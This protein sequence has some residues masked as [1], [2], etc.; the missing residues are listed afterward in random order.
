M[1]C[2]V[3]IWRVVIRVMVFLLIGAVIN[4]LVAAGCAARCTFADPMNRILLLTPNQQVPRDGWCSSLEAWTNI[5]TW[6]DTPART[7]Q[8][9]S[10]ARSDIDRMFQSAWWLRVQISD[11]HSQT[12]LLEQASG[13]ASR[14]V[15]LTYTSTYQG[16]SEHRKSAVLET[17]WPL[18]SFS[19]LGHG[20]WIIDFQ[21]MQPALHIG[22]SGL[23]RAAT[24]VP[25]RPL[26][27]GTLV[28]TA[29]YA[30]L[31]WMVI[32]VPQAIRHARRRKHGLCIACKYPVNDLAKCPECGTPVMSVTS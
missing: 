22:D 8:G 16:T 4:W 30:A 17:G 28:N 3:K 7:P 24:I 18:L 19:C 2:E 9:E 25:L 6:I 26:F 13:M 21:T 15:Q 12:L 31:T 1:G 14:H 5:S 11:A 23:W 32:V 10:A 20:D 29:T 27:I